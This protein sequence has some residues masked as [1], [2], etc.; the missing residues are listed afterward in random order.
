MRASVEPRWPARAPRRTLRF[1]AATWT[2]R[3]PC[4]TRCSQRDLS[5]SY[6]KL[7]DVAV[8]AGKLDDARGWFEK[9]LAVRKAL[10]EAD[11]SNAVWKRDLPV[12]YNNL[13]DVTVSAGK[14]D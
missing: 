8:S 7:G 13:G 4:I 12:S 1:S 9:A 6:N 3:L 2:K 11:A 14:L 10:A 5:F